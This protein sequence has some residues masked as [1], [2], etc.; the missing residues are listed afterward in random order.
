MSLQFIR[1]LRREWGVRQRYVARKYGLRICGRFDESGKLMTA[2]VSKR[3]SLARPTTEHRSPAQVALMSRMRAVVVLAGSMR[4]TRLR[5]AAGRFV[6]DLPVD[7]ERTVLDCWHDQVT[8][9][10]EYF[11]LER[12]PVRVMIDHATPAARTSSPERTGPV[13]LRIERDPLEFRGT[14]GLLRDLTSDY[15]DE[16]L[17]LVA[18]SPQLLLQPLS[19]VVETLASVEG[20]V[21]LLAEPDGTP[22]GLMLIRCGVLRGLPAVGFIDLKEQALP[23]IAEAHR[24]MVAR[25]E[26]P[27]GASVRTLAT[28]LD[29]L[30]QYHRRLQGLPVERGSLHEDWQPAFKLI[31]PGARVDPSAVIHDS[32]VLSGALVESSAVLV[33][34]VVAPG[35]YVPAGESVVDRLVTPPEPE[36]L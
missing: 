35:G 17:V 15:G 2:H 30:R 16:E 5:R 1:L 32:V 31:E 21:R 13:E 7:G 36:R 8:A 29:A 12:L 3:R 20:D 14:G 28:Y 26:G 9:L 4:P 6:M 25:H 34:S 27:C 23:M 10:A 11:D 18:G 19:E 22:G 33:R 24:V